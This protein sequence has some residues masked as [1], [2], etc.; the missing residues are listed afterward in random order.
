M[1][2]GKTGA[3]VATRVNFTTVDPMAGLSESGSHVSTSSVFH[4]EG[5]VWVTS[6]LENIDNMRESDDL[7][8]FAPEKSNTPQQFRWEIVDRRPWKESVAVAIRN[9]DQARTIP[10][11]FPNR[12]GVIESRQVQ[13]WS[14]T[15]GKSPTSNSG[16]NRKSR[17]KKDGPR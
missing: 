13:T 16:R 14:Q 15:S 17:H 3:L 6:H 12:N 9:K 7:K 8:N 10:W 1:A 11:T 2:I 4:V 5:S